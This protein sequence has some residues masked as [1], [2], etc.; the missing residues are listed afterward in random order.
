MKKVFLF[1]FAVILI[2]AFFIRGRS[3]KAVVDAPGI[4]PRIYCSPSFDPA[5]LTQDA[6]LLKGLGKFH[7]KVST[8]SK[9]AQL[10]FDQ[11]LAL[12]YG[13][14]HG[15]AGRSFNT[16][17]R[18][19][20]TLAMAY[21]GLAMVLGPNYN[22]ALNPTSL[23]EINRAVDQ[24]VKHAVKATS[25]EQ[26]FI[27]AIAKKFPREEVKDMTP[28]Y[29]AYAAEM[30]K[31]YEQFPGDVEFGTLYAEALMNLHPWN[32]WGKDGTPQPW[33]PQILQVLE[34]VLHNFPDHPGAIHYYI[35]A[36]EASRQAEKAIV[37]ADKLRNK[38]PDA[39]HLVHMPSH[40]Y[41]RT[42]DYHKGVIANEQSSAADSSYISQCKVQG[43]YPMLYYPHNLHFLTACAFLEGN[44]A[45]ALEAAWA[46]SGKAE[47]KFLAENAT[48]QH[49]YIIP[50]Y[51]LVHMARWD[52]ILQRENPGKGLLYPEAIWHYA[53]GMAYGAKGDLDAAATE[54][55]E[56]EKIAGEESLKSLMIWDLNSA[57]DL[58]NIARHV[59]EG[60]LQA[61]NREYSKATA[62][63][64]E[65]IAIEDKLNYNE[66]PDWFFSVRLTAGHWL[67]QC[68]KFEAAEKIFLEDLETFRENGWALMGLYKSLVGQGKV[69]AADEA[70]VRFDKAWQWA[71]IIIESSR[72]MQ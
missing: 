27:N 3:D 51:I 61:H 59:L 35:H 49:F 9:K 47:K 56:I 41:I 40:V 53:R 46:V 30:G 45:K 16:A 32:L 10:Y 7:Y 68:G 62:S 54:L 33:T 23:G 72:K 12:M 60:E 14:N 69:T 20:S 22:A 42:G 67:L 64:K 28:F 63:F 70:K 65:A 18:Y 8:R 11:G 17:L 36:T 39:G 29:E 58:V 24:A 2:P 71:D 1:L 43:V 44:S 5:K 50:Y 26:A 38:M 55:K 21:W 25:A 66:P 34:R 19:D 31:A 4:S 52:E 37:Y 57:A 15:E 13:F 48:V 6:P